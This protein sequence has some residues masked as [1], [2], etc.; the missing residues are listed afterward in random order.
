[1]VQKLKNNKSILIIVGAVLLVCIVLAIIACSITGSHDMSELEKMKMN[2]VSD[3]YSAY[4][5]YVEGSKDIGSYI[6]YALEYNYN[7][8]DK[9]E[10]KIEDMVKLLNNTF[11]KKITEDDIKKV[12]ITPEMVDK[13]ITADE[14]SYK[15][16]VLEP[17]YAE[18]AAREIT[19]Y[20]VKEITKTGKNKYTVKYD[21]IIVENPYEV[22]NYY[23]DK[24][25]TDAA[26]E[27]TKYLKGEAKEITIKKYITD[28][29]QSKVGKKK[30]EVTVTY[31][32]KDKKVLIDNIK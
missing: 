30:K 13:N 29:N 17:S 27:I 22:L 24:N 18:I 23:N 15:L 10:M 12:G 4:L 1:M 9:K 31:I 2:E 19:K 3:E 32:V 8:N 11:T 26:N 7:V 21:K 14:E 6:I 25:D 28:K 16:N 20:N 5:E